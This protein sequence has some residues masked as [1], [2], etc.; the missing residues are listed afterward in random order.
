[1]TKR[2]D[3]VV[4]F[5]MTSFVPEKDVQ[6]YF[7]PRLPPTFHQHGSSGDGTGFPIM[8]RKI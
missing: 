4:E 3:K 2:P 6:K 1:V 5:T 7:P 8:V